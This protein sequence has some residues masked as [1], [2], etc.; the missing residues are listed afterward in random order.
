MF[1]FRIESVIYN[2]LD[3]FLITLEGIKSHITKGI[4]NQIHPRN[5]TARGEKR[6]KRMKRESKSAFCHKAEGPSYG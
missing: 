1:T 4:Q 6:L 2:I 3:V 5:D